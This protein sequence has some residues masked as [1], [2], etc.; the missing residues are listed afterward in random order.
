MKKLVALALFL[1][2]PVIALAKP[3]LK[4]KSATFEFGEVS[5]G[6]IL[7]IAFEFENSGDEALLIKNVVPSCG[8]TTAAL[9]KK[10]YKPGEKGTISG[11]FNTSGYNGRVV[12]TI[13]VTSN[14]PANPEIR[15]AVSGT[16]V[17]KDFAQAD[18]KPGQIAFGVVKVGKAYVRK[19]N[20]SNLGNMDLRVL[21]Y[22][23]SPECRWRSARAAWRGRTAPSSP[24]PSPPSRKGRSTTW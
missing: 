7:D 9:D 10:E 13:T 3:A 8:C 21:E 1:L 14:D 18:V 4:F 23:C 6:K 24:S 15:L 12:K 20:L 5:S 2:L 22:S 11:K 17:V 16:V 19:L